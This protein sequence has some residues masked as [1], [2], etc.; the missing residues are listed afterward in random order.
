[1]TKLEILHQLKNTT[2]LRAEREQLSIL[3]LEDN[4]NFEKLLE[5]VFEV[6]NKNSV[7]ATWILELVCENNI[8][9]L[10]PY[11]D[12]FIEKV[13]LITEESAI[14]P[15]SKIIKFLMEQDKRKPIIPLTIEHKKALTQIAFDWMIS[16]CKVATKAYAMS[17]LFLLGKEIDWIHRELK[18]VIIDNMDF[19]TAAYKSR[20]LMTIKAINKYNKE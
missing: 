11:L 9:L 3:I 13:P 8:Q 15:I 14:R 5:I 12:N 16:D 2:A 18:Q 1:M 20:G 4:K 10:Y 6:E 7:K 17:S 19:E